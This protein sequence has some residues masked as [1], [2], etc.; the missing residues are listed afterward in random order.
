MLDLPADV[1]ALL[2]QF[3]PLFTPS[4][5]YHAQVL[6]IGALLT[7]GKR[8]VIA[9]LSVMGL[10]QNRHFYLVTTLRTAVA[11]GPA[12]LSDKEWRAPKHRSREAQR[13]ACRSAAG[14][15]SR[16]LL[17]AASAESEGP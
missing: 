4:V 7:P 1:T 2:A 9:V 13:A 3:A 17:E 6:V 11:S 16:Q 12:P 8:T 10:R 5:W 15:R 14:R